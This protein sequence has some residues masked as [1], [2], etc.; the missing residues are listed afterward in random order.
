MQKKLKKEVMNSNYCISMNRV[1]LLGAILF[2]CTAFGYREPNYCKIVD[3]VTKGFLKEHVKPRHI[4]LS[5]YGGAMMNDIQEI[6]LSFLSYEALN[7]EEARV[8]YVEMM[9][10]YLRRINCNEKIRP[11]LHNFPFGI[12]N[13]K[14]T[15]GFEDRERQIAQ[16]GHVA[17]MFIGK[18]HEL[19]F[20]G[21][22]PETE[23]FYSLHRESYE[24][25]LKLVRESANP[26][27]A[28][29]KLAITN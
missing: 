15:I 25:A 29:R 22:D 21:Y 1:F 28:H 20:R 26:D 4:M 11:Y 6:F 9:E 5:G 2:L 8:L 19:H 7:V 17:L 24:E 14:L 3:R 12:D 13:I 23:E 10:E 18:N 27:S 16:D